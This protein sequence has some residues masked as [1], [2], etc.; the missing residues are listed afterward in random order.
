MTTKDSKKWSWEHIL[1]LFNGPLNSPARFQETLKTKLVKRLIS[2]FKPKKKLFSD[3]S[4]TED[5]MKYVDLGCQLIETCLA[6]EDGC[7]LLQSSGFLEQIRD[8]LQ[9]ELKN[10]PEKDPNRVLS[11]QKVTKTMCREYFTLIGKFSYIPQGIYMLQDFKI[12]D[13]L[14]Q[15]TINSNR[16]DICQLIIK[17]MN[18]NHPNSKYAR[19][20]LKGAMQA[21]SKVKFV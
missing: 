13:T 16:D 19:K 21:S 10:N 18:Y 5:S 3:L 15:L 12:F 1:R 20:I 8:M 2:F 9:I 11:P 7:K 17:H 14:Y 6:T 4:Y